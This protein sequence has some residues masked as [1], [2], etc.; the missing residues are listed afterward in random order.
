[1]GLAKKMLYR[2][3]AKNGKI[4]F[5]CIPTLDKATRFMFERHRISI[6]QGRV[7]VSMGALLS[8]TQ[9]DCRVGSLQRAYTRLFW[10]EKGPENLSNPIQCVEGPRMLLVWSLKGCWDLYW[11][12]LGIAKK[13]TT[14]SLATKHGWKISHFSDLPHG[15]PPWLGIIHGQ[16]LCWPSSASGWGLLSH[17]SV[18]LRSLEPDSPAGSAT[19]GLTSCRCSWTAGTTPTLMAALSW[20]LN[21]GTRGEDMGN[22]GKRC[23]MDE[24]VGDDWG[25]EFNL[26]RKRSKRWGWLGWG[27]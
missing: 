3:T 13:K 24:D 19:D 10:W 27:W 14:Y 21:T 17:R 15:N 16:R 23:T 18:A 7:V 22:Q 25:H 9:V 5:W 6:Q 26:H 12:P 11:N 8:F 1:M 4:G 2:I 20:I